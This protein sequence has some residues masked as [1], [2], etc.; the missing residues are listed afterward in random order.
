MKPA[1]DITEF[2]HGAVAL[3]LVDR[4][5]H[6]SRVADAAPSRLRDL[7]ELTKPRM[8]ALVVVT[9][10]VGFFMAIPRFGLVNWP[11]LLHTILGTSLTAAGASVLNQYVER[12]LDRNMRRTADRPLPSGRLSAIEALLMGVSLGIGGVLYL[13]AFV[14]PLTALL[15]AFT[16]G[17]YVWI[18][19]PMKRW[20]TLCT[21]VGAIPG[22]VPPVMGWTAIHNSVSAEALVL[23]GILFLWQMPHFL[24]IAVLYKD[25]YAAGGFAMLPCVDP[26]L[27]A[28]GRQILVYLLSLLPVTLMPFGLRM[29]G[30]G[31][32]V[33]AIALGAFFTTYGIQ[34]ARSRTR[35]DARKLFFVSIVYLPLL[36]GAL[37]VDKV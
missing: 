10:G 2:P 23:F 3:P 13:S 29:A 9:T 20:T 15:G 14:N 16:L 34:A 22:A 18:Y 6:P 36:L 5:G 25:D 33:S 17:S 11:L 30:A 8:N 21:V 35:E 1:T 7:Y 4:A 27:R 37:M 32:L 12:D 24:A 28:T 31:Y 26:D 19:T